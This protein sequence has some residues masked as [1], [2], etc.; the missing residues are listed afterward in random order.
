MHTTRTW[1]QRGIPH[2]ICK[3]MHTYPGPVM[4]NPIKQW[5]IYNLAWKRTWRGTRNQ[6]NSKNEDTY[7]AGDTANRDVYTARY[8]YTYVLYICYTDIIRYIIYGLIYTAIHIHI[9]VDIYNYTYRP[10]HISTEKARETR[11]SR[12]SSRS[13]RPIRE[14]SMDW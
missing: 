5:L 9:Y 6:D 1:S 2:W 7:T 13:E 4:I 8:V 3:T 12:E 14:S 11:Q 10:V